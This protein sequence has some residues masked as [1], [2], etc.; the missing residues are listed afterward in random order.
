MTRGIN[1]SGGD[2]LQI[3]AGAQG[4]ENAADVNSVSASGNAFL[5]GHSGNSYADSH[6][7][8]NVDQHLDQMNDAMA[9]DGGYDNTDA[10]TDIKI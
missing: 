4:A 10:N 6:L 2:A 3:N 1:K 9:G 7:D 5:D 8:Q